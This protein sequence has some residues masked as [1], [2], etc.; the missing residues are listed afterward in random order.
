MREIMKNTFVVLAIVATAFLG[1][2]PRA[3][4]ETS[5]TAGAGGIYP[6]GT[7]FYGV[8]IN[9]L[10]SDYGV[11]MDDSGSGLGQFCTILLGVS[12]LGSPQNII[13]Y[14]KVTSGSRAGTNIA[15]FSG[16]CTIDLG[17]GTPPIL[18]VPFTATIT[19]NTNDQGT[20]GLLLGQTTLPAATVSEGS[21][22]IR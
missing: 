13:I 17:N 4:A 22:T 2:P 20:I 14:G 6:P 9:G 15:T 8:P 11:N 19:T 18:G 10:Q 16:T 12:A 5:V 21:M 7:S 3:V 1:L